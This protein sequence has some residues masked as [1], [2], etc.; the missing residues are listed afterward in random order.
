M[1]V[2][3]DGYENRPLTS[4]IHTKGEPEGKI[5]KVHFTGPTIMNVRK[6]EFLSN[7]RQILGHYDCR[8]SHGRGDADVLFVLT[9]IHMHQLH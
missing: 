9:T 6:D 3:F 7:I 2:V 5:T 4:T 8:I 1:V